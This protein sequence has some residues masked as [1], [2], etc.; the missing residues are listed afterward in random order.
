V[1]ELPR[2]FGGNGNFPIPPSPASCSPVSCSSVAR[3]STHEPCHVEPF[4][5]IE[6]FSLTEE[7]EVEPFDFIEQSIDCNKQ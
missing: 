3:I 5:T 4:D 1:W 7:F 6:L 2:G